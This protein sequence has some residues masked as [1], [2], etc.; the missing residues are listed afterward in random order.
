VRI[1]DLGVRLA[2]C[3]LALSIAS[4]AGA[5]GNLDRGKTAAQLYAS[6]CATCHKSP[7]SVATTRWIFGLESFLN[8]HYTSSGESAAILAAY[9]K[10]QGKSSAGPQR[11]SITL[12]R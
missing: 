12:D 5:E 4:S 8:E 6:D 2:I 3:S 1:S 11:G 7:Q 9:L 10:T